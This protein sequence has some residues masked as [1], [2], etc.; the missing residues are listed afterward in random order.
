MLMPRLLIKGYEGR[1]GTKKIMLSLIILLALF[2]Q[3]NPRIAQHD[4]EDDTDHDHDHDNGGG[5]HISVFR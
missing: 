2:S 3:I 5:C 1:E 4:A